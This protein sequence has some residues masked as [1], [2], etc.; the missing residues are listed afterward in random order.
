MAFSWWKSDVSHVWVMGELRAACTELKFFGKTNE[1]SRH[2]PRRSASASLL[3][4]TPHL[5]DFPLKFSASSQTR[6]SDVNR[7]RKKRCLWCIAWSLGYFIVCLNLT[8]RRKKERLSSLS[9][10]Y[11]KDGSANGNLQGVHPPV[12]VHRL[13]WQAAVPLRV[14]L[15][16]VFVCK[17]VI[18]ALLALHEHL[19]PR[20]KICGVHACVSAEALMMHVSIC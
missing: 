2:R 19:R 9:I 4:T 16:C 12:I 5:T 13:N 3:G 18:F 8:G 1:P 20:G 6:G 17:L 15:C 11:I 10:S 7:G 14:E